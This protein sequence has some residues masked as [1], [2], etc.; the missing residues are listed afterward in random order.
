MTNY[1]E[2]DL[3][4]HGCYCSVKVILV[5]TKYCHPDKARSATRD[6]DATNTAWI[7]AQH[8]HCCCRDWRIRMRTPP[9]DGWIRNDKFFL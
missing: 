3:L 1:I 9:A 5:K 8:P 2:N 4:K 6:L 7:D